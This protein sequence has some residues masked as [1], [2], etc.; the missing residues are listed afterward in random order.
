MADIQKLVS[1]V[2]AQKKKCEQE[3][4]KL[5]KLESKLAIEQSKEISQLVKKYNITDMNVLEQALSDWQLNNQEKEN[6]DE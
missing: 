5:D 3:K 2:E 4:M 6:E 1:Q